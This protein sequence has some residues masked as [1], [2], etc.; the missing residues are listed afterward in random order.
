MHS[1]TTY[2]QLCELL[3]FTTITRLMVSDAIYFHSK[4]GIVEDLIYH[5]HL[6]FQKEKKIMKFKLSRSSISYMKE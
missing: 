5:W 3:L 2:I 6:Y 4:R 1:L